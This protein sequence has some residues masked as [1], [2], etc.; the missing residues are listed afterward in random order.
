MKILIRPKS[1]CI[2]IEKKKKKKTKTSFSLDDSMKD[3]T[4]AH[5]AIAF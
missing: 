2:E 3:V 5:N 1:K 4:P